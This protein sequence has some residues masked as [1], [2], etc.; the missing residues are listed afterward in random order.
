MSSAATAWS[1]E[2]DAF[3]GSRISR[4]REGEIRMDRRVIGPHL[5]SLPVEGGGAFV[6]GLLVS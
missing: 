5:E 3:P 1:M 4:Q 6:I 2:L